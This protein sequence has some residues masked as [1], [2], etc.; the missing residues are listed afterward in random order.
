MWMR[1]IQCEV[2]IL[3]KGQQ[4]ILAQEGQGQ[5]KTLVQCADNPQKVAFTVDRT[6]DL[7]IFSLTL[8][9]LSYKSIA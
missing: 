8:S 1:V 9:Q 7:N 5:V 4:N 2:C 3:P 6:R